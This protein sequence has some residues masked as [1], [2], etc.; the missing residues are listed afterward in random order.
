[1]YISSMSV[2]VQ[3]VFCICRASTQHKETANK[4]YKWLA[5]HVS[6]VFCFGFCFYWLFC[7][8]IGNKIN[9]IRETKQLKDL[10]SELNKA[11]PV[12]G[13]RH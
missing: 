8:I 2:L 4:L 9:K 3:T 5:L 6:N 10:L 12:Y 7:L 13:Q 1:M 11:T